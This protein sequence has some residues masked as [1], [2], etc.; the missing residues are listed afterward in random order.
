[1]ARA[2]ARSLFIVIL[3]LALAGLVVG[4][5]RSSGPAPESVGVLESDT[6]GGNEADAARQ[7]TGS[8]WL[9][10][11]VG[12]WALAPDPLFDRGAEDPAELVT[13][14]PEAVS[15]S[16]GKARS[17]ALSSAP[18]RIPRGIQ[19][20]DS[21]AVDGSL[22]LRVPDAAASDGTFTFAVTADMRKY[23]GPGQ[24][25]TAGYFRGALEAIWAVASTAF[26]VSPGDIDPVA[27]VYWTIT[28]TL[29][30]TYTWYPAVGNHELPGTGYEDARG[31]NLAWLNDYAYEGA[32]Q[33]PSGCPTTTYSFDYRSTHFVVL[34]EY[35]DVA[36]DDVTNGDVTDHLYEWLV[37]DLAATDK[38]HILVFGH[39]PAYPQPDEGNGRVRHVGDSLDQHPAHRDRFWT[40]LSERGVAAYVCGHTHNYS[41]VQIDGVW[42]IDVGHA[43]G[44][45][46]TGARSTFVVIHVDDGVV[47]FEAYRDDAAGGPYTYWA[48]ATLEGSRQFLPLLVHETSS[49]PRRGL[50][51][52]R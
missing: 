12:G 31:D 40:L 2:P 33:G 9:K 14:E 17:D 36:G 43:R 35:C 49:S 19:V 10:P 18:N 20:R 21:G 23:S 1:M 39:E 52:A 15:F 45:G 34:N 51:R 3:G 44:L 29:G 5:V 50:R 30:V 24:Y 25:D 16:L 47:T 22:G 38:E 13:I 11:S 42:Q 26:M 37:D 46:D 27:D 28:S 48:G 41:T 8:H 6:F 4:G 32:S 7:V